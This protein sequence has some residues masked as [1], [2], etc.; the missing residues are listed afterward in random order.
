MS[1]VIRIIPKRSRAAVSLPANPK[2]SLWGST[3]AGDLSV[4]SFITGR[5]GAWRSSFNVELLDSPP[6]VEWH[7]SNGAENNAVVK[8]QDT[9]SKAK[10]SISCM[11]L[12]PSPLDNFPDSRWLKSGNDLIP[13]SV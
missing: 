9:D 4:T 11:D 1:S 13:R 8:L 7:Y 12:L 5:S 10:L 6:I 3:S 2:E